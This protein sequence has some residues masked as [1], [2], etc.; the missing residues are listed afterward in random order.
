MMRFLFLFVAFLQIS[1]FDAHSRWATRED[2]GVAVNFFQRDINIKKR[3]NVSGT[4]SYK[5]DYFK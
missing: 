5:D 1:F 2:V 3:W 4:F